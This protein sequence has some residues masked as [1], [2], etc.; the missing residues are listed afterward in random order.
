M[1]AIQHSMSPK[2][3]EKSRRS[4][5]VRGIGESHWPEILAGLGID[6][7]FLVR[8]HAP[9]PA[10]GGKDRFRFD[11]REGRGTFY[12]NLCSA[13]DGIRLI[14]NVFGWTFPD[15]LKAVSDFWEG[16][17][18][19]GTGIRA[20]SAAKERPSRE[21]LI[22]RLLSEAASIQKMDPV[23]TYLRITR[24][25]DMPDDWPEALRFHPRMLHRSDH[26]DFR[27][28]AL[29]GTIFALDGTFQG[30]HITYLTSQ[31]RKADV[32]PQKRILKAPPNGTINGSAIRLGLPDRE[33][34]LGVSEGLETGLSAML[35]TGIPVWCGLSAN[36]MKQI[37]LPKDARDVWIFADR[38]PNGTGQEA[39]RT[40][41]VRLVAEGRRI[42]V[43]LPKGGC[44]DVNDALFQK[45]EFM[46]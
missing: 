16:S 4:D 10:C 45:S 39:A 12:C 46:G 35:L 37:L 22:N 9:C 30:L 13:G 23:D 21:R 6:P 29:V 42:F 3:N 15:A 28:P 17:P 7:R 41:S 8:R 27:H 5:F 25:V 40:F 14:Q 24:R 36:G 38:D 34:R 18:I 11:D 26:G 2:N 32:V 44:K 19:P 20:S 31:G 33:G 1:M 43:V